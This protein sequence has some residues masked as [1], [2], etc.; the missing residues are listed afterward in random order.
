MPSDSS[1]YYYD[2]A[3]VIEI[4]KVYGYDY[5][6]NSG[7]EEHSAARR[8][9]VQILRHM[10]HVDANEENGYSSWGN[11]LVASWGNPNS[12]V[13]LYADDIT[14]HVEGAHFCG[15]NYNYM[16]LGHLLLHITP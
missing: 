6:H 13:E 16:K 1:S 7:N 10:A 5:M 12:P 14:N 3:E 15:N 11:E 2:A 9:T 4:Y 8:G